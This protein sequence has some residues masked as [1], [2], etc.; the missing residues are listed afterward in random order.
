MNDEVNVLM[1]YHWKGNFHINLQ[2][3]RKR[4]KVLILYVI[5]RKDGSIFE[6]IVI[7]SILHGSLWINEGRGFEKF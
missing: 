1:T 6:D 2:P 4:W 5:W 3:D 7:L